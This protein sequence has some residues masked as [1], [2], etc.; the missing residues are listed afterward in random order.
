M[1][2]K[3][4]LLVALALILSLSLIPVSSFAEYDD[5]D[6]DDYECDHDW[7]EYEYT[8][9]NGTY[10]NTEYHCYYC[11]ETKVEKEKHNF[12]PTDTYIKVDNTYHNHYYECSDCGYRKAIK[13]KHVFSGSS[14]VTQSYATLKKRANVRRYCDRGDC[15]AYRTIY[16]SWNYKDSSDEE[17]EYSTSYWCKYP[18]I[19]KNTRKVTLRLDSA[20]K[21]S[22]IKLKIGKKTY[23]K[24]IN[25]DSTR[26]VKIKIK[27][28]KFGQKVSVKIYYGKRLIGEDYDSTDI[29]TPG[30]R[31]KKGMK[32][33]EVK[34]I[35]GEPSDT[36]SASGGW[37]YWFYDDGSY[38]SFKRGKVKKWYDAA[39]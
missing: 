3:K 9:L 38:V 24:K 14:D 1:K 2:V 32:K 16:K 21:G 30:N 31:V 28:P 5:Y 22:V 17:P 26:A 35:W 8:K 15:T 37:S 27:K 33:A 34:Y 13:E 36:A 23:K 25:S 11:Y 20:I 39:E 4:H 12:V 29:V 6:Y 7:Y 18:D 19:T 10:H